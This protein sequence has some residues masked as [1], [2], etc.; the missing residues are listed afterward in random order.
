MQQNIPLKLEELKRRREAFMD[1]LKG[2][3]RNV[4]ALD[5]LALWITVKV[6]SMGFFLIIFLWTTCW[7]SWNIF[8]PSNL[9]FDPYPGFVLWLFI[10]NMIQLFLMPLIMIGQNLQSHHADIRAEADLKINELSD[11]ENETILIHLENQNE[12][13][14]EILQNMQSQKLPT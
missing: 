11:I 2:D 1:T 3:K 14:L 4:S 6:G 12:M 8:A 10:S 9:R 7:L 5:K 13:I